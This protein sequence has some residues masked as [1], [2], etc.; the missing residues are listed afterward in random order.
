MVIQ[1]AQHVRRLVNQ[2][3]YTPWNIISGII[4]F[5]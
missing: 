4:C 1:P 3:Q 2:A 5:V